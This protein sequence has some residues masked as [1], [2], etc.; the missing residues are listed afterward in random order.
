MRGTTAKKL[1]TLTGFIPAAERNYDLRFVHRQ[2]PVP[3][4]ENYPNG[5]ATIQIG[6]VVLAEGEAKAKYKKMKAAF[7]ADKPNILM[8][9]KVF[10]V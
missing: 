3:M 1:R 10:N 8:L 4:S 5:V 9:L 2:I 7:R 6:R